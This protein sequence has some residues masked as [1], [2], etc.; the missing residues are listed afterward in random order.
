MFSKIYPRNAVP[1]VE[2]IFFPLLVWIAWH[3]ESKFFFFPSIY[4]QRDMHLMT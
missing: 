3:R 4:Y 2:E 1:G